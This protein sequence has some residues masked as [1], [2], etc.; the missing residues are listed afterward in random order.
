MSNHP[1]DD[2]YWENLA[3]YFFID[4][5]RVRNLVGTKQMHKVKE[6]YIHPKLQVKILKRDEWY[7][8]RVRGK[9]G[10]Y[11]DPLNAKIILTAFCSGY[12]FV[13]QNK[14]DNVVVI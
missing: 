10:N 5:E 3:K 7:S 12:A 4:L 14:P 2:E 9:D 1:D 8:Y 13:T 6:I 11:Y